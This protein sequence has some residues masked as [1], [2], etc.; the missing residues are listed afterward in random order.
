MHAAFTIAAQRT[1]WLVLF[2]VGLL[3]CAVVMTRF[4]AKP[5]TRTLLA[6]SHGHDLSRFAPPPPLPPSVFHTHVTRRVFFPSP[7]AAREGA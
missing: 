5:R 7:G 2:L 4:E 6:I 1:P 3:L